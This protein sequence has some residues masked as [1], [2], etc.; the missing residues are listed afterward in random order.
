MIAS[1]GAD[2]FGTGGVHK[3]DR[4]FLIVKAVSLVCR[5]LPARLQNAGCLRATVP[6]GAPRLLIIPRA[7]FLDID[8][9]IRDM[10]SVTSPQAHMS[11]ASDTE[12]PLTGVERDAEPTKVHNTEIRCDICLLFGHD[13]GKCPDRK[14][15]NCGIS[16]QH[17]SVFCPS[18]P[19]HYDP[20]SCTLCHQTGHKTINAPCS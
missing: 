20:Q 9:R 17:P 5:I 19:A 15:A 7:T 2:N 13:E 16:D 3:R 14:C 18:L 8:N 10:M 11:S 1:L 6:F 4:K 12:Q